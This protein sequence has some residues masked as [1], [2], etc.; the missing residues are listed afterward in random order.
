[1]IDVSEFRRVMG[2]F[3]SGV[4]VVTTVRDDDTP[5]GL[6]AS[7]VCSVSLD[8]TMILVCVE[9]AA[10][11]HE[12]IENTGIFAVNVLGEGKGETLARRFA[13][14]NL[15]GKFEGVA[16]RPEHTG[17]PVLDE[18][19]AWLDCRVAERCTGGDHTVFVGEVVA[20][21][22]S[23]G[24]PLLYYRGGYGRFAP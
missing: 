6:T 7:A 19:L 11:S 5:C 14:H 9:R 10:A 8:P 17:A 21:D 3:A 16:Y 15:D 18:A 22:T 4:A 13:G 23:D 24:A 1:M 12:C 20:A 2:H